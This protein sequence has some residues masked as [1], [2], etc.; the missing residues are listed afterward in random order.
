[1]VFACF[2]FERSRRLGGGLGLCSVHAVERYRVEGA[3][4]R[5]VLVSSCL[6][7]I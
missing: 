6:L 5:E 3:S 2:R 7:L 1:M 4:A